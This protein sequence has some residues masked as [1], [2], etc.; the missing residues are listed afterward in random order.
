MILLKC[1]LSWDQDQRKPRMGLTRLRV[2]N[3]SVFCF[4]YHRPLPSLESASLPAK[5]N[6]IVKML[7][8]ASHNIFRNC[9]LRKSYLNPTPTTLHLI[10]LKAYRNLVEK[11]A[12]D[13]DSLHI[14]MYMYLWATILL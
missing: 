11:K 9:G 3:E 2:H 4:P 14:H 5:R 7:D 10:T 13:N 1:Y 8:K 6:Y 12:R